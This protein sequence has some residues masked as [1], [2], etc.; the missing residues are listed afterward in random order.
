MGPGRWGSRGDIK[1]G[2]NVTYS[3]INN[4]AVLIEI[5][6]KNGNYVPDVSFGTHFFQDLVEAHIR[7]LPLYPDD[8]A[9]IFNERFLKD[10][11]NVLAE[12]LPEFSSLADTVHVIDIPRVA[13][14]RVLHLLM[15]SEQDQAVGILANPRIDTSFQE[16]KS[17]NIEGNRE[18][19]WRWRLR[20]AEFIAS[21]LDPVA[22]SVKAMYL[23]GSTKN[24][25]AGPQSD[26]DLLIHFYGNE[27]QLGLLKAWLNGWSLCLSEMN[28]LQTG[29]KTNGLLDVHIITDEDIRN[30][31]SYA[32]KIDAVTDAARP[33]PLKKTTQLQ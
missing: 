24:G 13:A 8:E 27:L 11:P 3:E 9:I 5:A 33:L 19:S 1:L 32:V 7:Y 26:I 14:G 16:K 31:S 2:V 23:F 15:N 10:S 18:E 29:V 20:M 4:T 22:F 21:E 30:R 12:I 28:Y 17:P 6:R 25:T